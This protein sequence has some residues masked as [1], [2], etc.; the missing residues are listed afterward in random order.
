[1]GAGFTLGDVLS[2]T[3]QCDST[4]GIN[5]TTHIK[6][7]DANAVATTK[8]GSLGSWDISTETTFHEPAVPEPVTSGLVGMGL[9]GLFFVGRR[10]SR[11]SAYDLVSS[12]DTPGLRKQPRFAIIGVTTL[13][14]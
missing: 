2:W 7:I 4:K 11:L 3:C 14:G 5:D 12:K 6:Y 8:V 10:D 13:G 1:M 9:I